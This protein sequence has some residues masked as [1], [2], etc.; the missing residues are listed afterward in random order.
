MKIIYTKVIVFFF[1]IIMILMGFSCFAAKD[2]N[3]VHS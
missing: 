1:L 3:K 2:D